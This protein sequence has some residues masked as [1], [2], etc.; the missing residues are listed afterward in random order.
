MNNV[1]TLLTSLF[2]FMLKQL[3]LQTN[4]HGSY[5]VLY[6][7]SPRSSK[8]SLLCVT[9]DAHYEQLPI[10]RD[11]VVFFLLFLQPSNELFQKTG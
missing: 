11:D 1:S 4:V 2:L 8:T 6:A 3:C 5:G 9:Y 7:E 10:H